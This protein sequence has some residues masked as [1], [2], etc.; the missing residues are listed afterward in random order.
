MLAFLGWLLW[1]PLDQA[2]L[3]ALLQLLCSSWKL[4]AGIGVKVASCCI[5]GWRRSGSYLGH[6][7]PMEDHKCQ[8]DKPNI[9]I[10]HV[11]YYCWKQVIRPSPDQQ[12]GLSQLTVKLWQRWVKKMKNWDKVL[13]YEVPES[14]SFVA[15]LLCSV[16]SSIHSEIHWVHGRFSYTVL[17]SFSSG[18]HWAE[19]KIG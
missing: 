7:L 9:Q 14:I 17:I 6:L 3:A 13:I 15:S 4:L 8:E 5:P 19:E 10:C 2:W 16:Q 18:K 12:E 11:D 1:S